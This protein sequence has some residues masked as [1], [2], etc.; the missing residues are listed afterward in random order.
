LPSN[1]IFKKFPLVEK[2]YNYIFN[3]ASSEREELTRERMFEKYPLVGKAYQE[4]QNIAGMMGSSLPEAYDDFILDNANA[5]E[6]HIQGNHENKEAVIVGC[7]LMNASPF[8][9]DDIRRF[10]EEYTPQVKTI[11]DYILRGEDELLANTPA[12]SQAVAI[13]NLEH[14]NKALKELAAGTHEETYSVVPSK[15][16]II[17]AEFFSHLKN[18]D[19]NLYAELEKTTNTYI[20][21]IRATIDTPTSGPKTPRL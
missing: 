21:A 7:I 19:P 6:T 5:V 2:A 14:I 10:E 16:E 13:T 17:P 11:V 12:I 1:Y 9:F 15:E 18:S 3:Q 8:T 4:Q 20:E